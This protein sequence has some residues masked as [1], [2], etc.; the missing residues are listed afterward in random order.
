MAASGTRTNPCRPQITRVAFRRRD[1]SG[2]TLRSI[3]RS[4]KVSAQT[5]QSLTLITRRHRQLM[6]L[7]RQLRFNKQ[8]FPEIPKRALGIMGIMVTQGSLESRNP[9]PNRSGLQ[10]YRVIV[11]IT[12][13]SVTSSCGS[14]HHL[15]W[16]KA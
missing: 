11:G 12:Q 3:G 2:E 6:L 10:G 7:D 14:W 8:L 15:V 9:A 13:S 1:D 16:V 5:I 4:Y